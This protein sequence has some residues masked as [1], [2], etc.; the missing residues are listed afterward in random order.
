MAAVTV[1]GSTLTVISV[2]TAPDLTSLTVPFSWLRALSLI[3]PSL[4]FTSWIQVRM[5]VVDRRHQ[6]ELP[7]LPH[8]YRRS[9]I[10]AMPARRRRSD[11]PP[12]HFGVDNRA[13]MYAGRV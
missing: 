12:H 1:S 4:L 8:G 11:R 7:Q 5:L 3:E 2:I 10:A 6:V 9:V 13:P